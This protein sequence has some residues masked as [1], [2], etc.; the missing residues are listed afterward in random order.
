[1]QHYHSSSRSQNFFKTAE[2]RVG[3]LLAFYAV[4]ATGDA[5]ARLGDLNAADYAYLTSYAVEVTEAQFDTAERLLEVR[6][7]VE[8]GELKV[9]G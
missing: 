5:T 1:M 9:T 4:T 8:L 3:I 2:G 7:F 6:G